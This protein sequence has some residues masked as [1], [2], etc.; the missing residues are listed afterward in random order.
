MEC[1][2]FTSRIL[3][4]VIC[5]VFT[6][7]Y[8]A[9]AD[10]K[11]H[12]SKAHIFFLPIENGHIIGLVDGKGS[13]I[14]P[15]KYE[16]IAGFSE[17][18]P[19]VSVIKSV[20]G[21]YGYISES[22][23]YIHEPTLDMARSF[24][25]EGLA[26]FQ[27]NGKWGYIDCTGKYWVEPKYEEA[28]P[29]SHGLAAVKNKGIWSYI[30]TKGK[31]LFDTPFIQAGPFSEA[32]I[33]VVRKKG[34]DKYGNAIYGYINTKGEWKLEPVYSNASSF[35]KG[36]RASV[37]VDGKWGIIDETGNWIL[38]PQHHDLEPF[39]EHGVTTFCSKYPDGG[40]I[41][42][43]GQVLLEGIDVKYRFHYSTKCQV[44]STQDSRVDFY[45]L[46]GKPIKALND[47]KYLLAG[48]FDDSCRSLVLRFGTTDWARVDREGK[49]HKLADEVLEPYFD[50]WIH[51][52]NSFAFTDGKF[53]P[54]ITK[55]RKLAYVDE[56]GK[57]AL[58]VQTI[59]EEKSDILIVR[60]ASGRELWRH[61][62]PQNTLIE[63]TGH[64]TFLNPN[65]REFGY[66]PPTTESIKKV[67]ESLKAKTPA[68][69]S[70][71]HGQIDKKGKD[72]FGAGHYLAH[73][74][75]NE[76]DYGHYYHVISMH[77]FEKEFEDVRKAIQAN[78]GSAL[79]KIELD[80]ILE[81][82]DEWYI[83][84]SVDLRHDDTAVWLVDDKFLIL[85]QYYS[86]EGG[87]ITSGLEL[88]LIPT[89]DAQRNANNLPVIA[90]DMITLSK[91]SD[92][93]IKT[94]IDLLFEFID[95]KWTAAQKTSAE[96]L[97]QCKNIINKLEIGN[98][99]SLDD[100]IWL[101][102]GLLCAYKEGVDGNG[103]DVGTVEQAVQVAENLMVFI[104]KHGLGTELLTQKGQFR[105][106]AYRFAG[107]FAWYIFKTDP[108]RA[109]KL[110]EKA[111]KYARDDEAFL[112]NTHVRV[113][114]ELKQFDKAYSI[115]YRVLNENSWFKD[116]QD[117]Y[118]DEGYIAWLKKNEKPLFSTIPSNKKTTL[119]LR[120]KQNIAV[121]SGTN[122]I[123]IYWN[124]EIHLFDGLSG[125]LQ[126]RIKT[127]TYD[128]F[129]LGF[130]ADGTK[131]ISSGWKKL[132]VWD[133]ATGSLMFQER[134]G[135]S[136]CAGFSYGDTN[137]YY[138]DTKSGYKG[139]LIIKK[140]SDHKRK[141][142]LSVWRESPPPPTEEEN[143]L[144]TLQNTRRGTASHDG[145]RLAIT[146][147]K[148]DD[149]DH[150]AIIDLEQA[151]LIAELSGE[152]ANGYKYFLDENKKLLVRSFSK[153]HLWNIADQKLEMSWDS[154]D[155]DVHDD[156]TAVCK[157]YVMVVD[158]D[159]HTKFSKALW[160]FDLSPGTKTTIS[161]PKYAD[162]KLIE[163]RLS[164]DHTKY[165]ITK[166]NSCKN[167]FY[168]FVYDV[169]TDKLLHE[170]VTPL[171]FY[172]AH[173]INNDKYLVLDSY[174]VQIVDCEHGKLVHEIRKMPEQ[175]KK[176]KTSQK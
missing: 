25:S 55:K 173:F 176:W 24:T 152:K 21:K 124:N 31:V 89:P 96:I 65:N 97:N 128:P 39:D 87:Y 146:L 117:F 161:F 12:S 30:D 9:L 68:L 162:G 103:I 148:D 27:K 131:L 115:V 129:F 32:G 2:V 172:K 114:I 34:K 175:P 84:D 100:Y 35:S 107:N 60:D 26:R 23:Q 81:E 61:S 64:R 113:L 130:N 3:P 18:C 14:V 171:R 120:K 90:P 82:L 4:F 73:L 142:D 132:S 47:P 134:A 88:M 94:E 85:E 118:E 20:K 166:T 70:F 48:E 7:S 16:H 163:L 109:L 5:F 6:L 44:I 159:D 169:K 74:Y 13:V 119:F 155:I 110:I 1:I 95:S 126:H 170:Y 83:H 108:A 98:R 15:P 133:T 154:R 42:E 59:L 69:F 158:D 28:E 79:S 168:A 106:T 105:L 8:S 93:S 80:T 141:S 135:N 46:G 112:N 38:K 160:K 62:Y 11:V 144:F 123:A 77:S 52:Y 50:T 157:E 91:Q 125:K 167:L 54:V 137:F 156:E 101:Q 116:F 99:I 139:R 147:E 58:Q 36:N 19:H 92:E 136:G 121:H 49:I 67:V 138:S 71:N 149:E 122:Q 76:A 165:V 43:D 63:T 57:I 145:R 29:F 153:F 40:L 86:V 37:E 104:E 140:P 111:V 10:P 78:Y 151:R 150:I 56:T 164:T 102:Y 41:N 127:A 72:I 45:A 174:P 66:T 17:G 143:T 33:A 22:G 75:Y 51:D 53:I